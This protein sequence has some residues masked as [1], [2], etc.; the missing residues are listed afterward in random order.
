MDNNLVGFAGMTLSSI[1]SAKGGKWIID[2]GASDHMTCDSE[3]IESI[4]IVRGEMAIT[5]PN[6]EC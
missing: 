2:S 3:Y 6:G 4:R 1:D 5:L